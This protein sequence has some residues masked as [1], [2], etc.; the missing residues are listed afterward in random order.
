[1]KENKKRWAKSFQVRRALIF[2]ATLMFPAMVIVIIIN[3]N[4]TGMSSGTR[5]KRMSSSFAKASEMELLPDKNEFTVSTKELIENNIDGTLSDAASFVDIHKFPT[6]KY[7]TAWKKDQ[8]AA[9]VRLAIVSGFRHIDTA[10]QPKH[11]NEAQVGEG[12]INAAEELG[13]VRQDIWI[14]TK[15]TSLNGQDPNNV[16][17]DKYASLD[18]QVNQSLAKSLKNLQTDYL[19]SWIMHGPENSWKKTLL[20]WRTMEAAVIAGTVR[21]I[22][23]SNFED[24]DAI[25]YLYNESLI[26]PKVVQNR[27]HGKTGYNVEIRKFCHN[28]DIEYQSFWTLGANRHALQHKN[29]IDLARFKSLTPQ[30]LMYAFCMAIGISPL[31]GTTSDLHM[32]EDVA[33]L[34]RLQSEVIFDNRK[35]LN[36]FAEALRI[37]G[38]VEKLE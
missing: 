32:L 31:D 5:K 12:W 4:S 24:L 14:Q 13:L 30:T 16:P 3:S 18:D 35:E 27:F 23:I 8:T 37:P 20:V 29:V 2:S 21:Q 1:M 17:Y 9:L 22:G 36:I 6:L 7:G 25:Q 11:Y 28:N 26:K 10:C 38:W 19:D 33:L 15:F 34:K